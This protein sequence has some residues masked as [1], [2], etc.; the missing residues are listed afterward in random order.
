MVAYAG[1]LIESLALL[2]LLPTEAVPATSTRPAVDSSV[3]LSN[4]L[5]E[6]GTLLGLPLGSEATF[7]GA[8]QA[9]P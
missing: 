9:R 4:C 7:D 8:I 2:S 6:L 3:G 5:E 1:G